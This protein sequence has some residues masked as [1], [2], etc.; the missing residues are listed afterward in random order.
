MTWLAALL[1]L[2]RPFAARILIALGFAAVTIGG[3]VGFI[4]GLRDL[5]VSKLDGIPQAALQL[6]AL[7][8]VFEGLQIIMGSVVFTMTLWGITKAKRLLGTYEFG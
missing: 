8:G 2:A 1:Q 4:N 6:A 7:A 5:L 3:V